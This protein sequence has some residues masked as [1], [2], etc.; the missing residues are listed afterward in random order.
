MPNTNNTLL[1]KW[2]DQ[3]WN[4]GNQQA[5]KEMFDADGI[6]HGVSDENGPKGPEGFATFYNDFRSQFSNVD[7]TV[8][9][10]VSEQDLESARCTVKAT[11]IDSGKDV[12]FSGLCMVR[13]RDGKIVEAWNHFDF[14][15]LYEQLG[16]K[17]VGP[18][19]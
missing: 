17:L 9:D 1:Y 19:E 12:A 5:I 6:A 7:I 2:F 16:H 15:N 14:L 11:H 8:E 3:V 18:G 4:Q 10:V 13:K